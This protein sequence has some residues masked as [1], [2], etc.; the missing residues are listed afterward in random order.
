MVTGQLFYSKDPNGLGRGPGFY[1]LRGGRHDNGFTLKSGKT[2][3]G[4][5]Y[6]K[7]SVVRDVN[8]LSDD[9]KTDKVGVPKTVAKKYAHVTDGDLKRKS[10][11]Y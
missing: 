6:S 1:Y 5:Y 9:W 7:Y 2:V 8:R 11:R 10:I 3:K 4:P